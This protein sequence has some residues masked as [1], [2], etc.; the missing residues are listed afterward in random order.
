M[1]TRSGAQQQASSAGRQVTASPSAARV[2]SSWR[3][4]TP[5]GS[6][7]AP[8]PPPGRGS[9]AAQSRTR[10]F[11]AP[12]RGRRPGR[13]PGALPGPRPCTAG[14]PACLQRSEL[15]GKEEGGARRN[16]IGLCD[17]SA[18]RP[19]PSWAAS[20]VPCRFHT[21]SHPQDRPSDPQAAPS[22][23]HP[24]PM[25]RSALILLVALLLALSTQGERLQ[26]AG[27]TGGVQ[28]R[29]GGRW[30][31]RAPAVHRWRSVRLVPCPR[32]PPLQ[33]PWSRSA[34]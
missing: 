27:A 6:C 29:C 3:P 25:A 21:H 17:A 22:A 24:A 32:P 34:L 9:P 12:R 7:S 16:G 1:A 13:C 33:A 10:T 23:P 20:R 28:G 18:R 4:P 14:R 11:H 2:G 15:E 19:S 31:A 8:C 5:L 26:R 30:Q